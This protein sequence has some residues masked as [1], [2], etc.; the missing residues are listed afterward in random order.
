VDRTQNGGTFYVGELGHA[1]PVNEHVPNLGPRVTVLD[2]KGQKIARFGGPFG[3]EKPGEFTA[4]HSVVTDSQGAVYV[5]EVSWTAGGSLETPPREIRSL[6][7]FAR[8]A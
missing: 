3:G 4:P 2:A 8:V 5:S 7:K 1:L 6:Q